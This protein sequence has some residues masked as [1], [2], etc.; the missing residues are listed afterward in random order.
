MLAEN[1]INQKNVAKLIK[2]YEPDY[3]YLPSNNE[4]ILKNFKLIE[5][6]NKFRLIKNLKSIKKKFN[7]NLSLLLSTSGS[8]GS[9]KFVRISHENLLFNT[10]SIVESLKIKSSHKAISTLPLNYTYGLSVINT[11]LFVGATIVLTENNILTKNFWL[12]LRKVGV[13]S[14]AGVPYIYEILNKLNLFKMHL[15]NLKYLTQAGGKLDNEFIIK[16]AKYCLKNK[17]KFIV[18]YGQVEATARISYLPFKKIFKKTGSIGKPLKN[19]KIEIW[20]KDGSKILKPNT[21]GELVFYGKNVS[22]GYAENYSDLNKGDHNKGVLKTGDN[23]FKDRDGFYYITGRN[24]RFSKL[25]GKRINLDDIDKEIRNFGYE[26]STFITNNKIYI[27]TVFNNKKNQNSINSIKNKIAD[28]LQIN[29]N[30]IYIKKIKNLPRNN[31][32]KILYNELFEKI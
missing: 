13:T 25:Y 23:V 31:Y 28:F 5:K 6:Y 11:H 2:N 29:S 22:L 18:M 24:D 15:P 12:L 7:K 16:F 32:G 9:P 8:T 27:F 17:K 4:L 20:D 21:N 3:I 1:N 10:L 26:S 19:C 30:F 14:L